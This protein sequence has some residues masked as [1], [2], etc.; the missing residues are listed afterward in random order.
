MVDTAAAEYTKTY[1][2]GGGRKLEGSTGLLVDYDAYL[3]GE[4]SAVVA[5]I[6]GVIFPHLNL[7]D[8]I[9]ATGVELVQTRVT[10]VVTKHSSTG[11]EW[12][13]ETVEVSP[14]VAAA[15]VTLDNAMSAIGRL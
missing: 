12:T 11:T 14:A 7:Q 5:N 2:G 15:A 8:E 3:A 1:S 9:D 6:M 4:S 13:G 10:E